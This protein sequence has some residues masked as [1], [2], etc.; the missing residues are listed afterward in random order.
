VLDYLYFVFAPE[1]PS[2]PATLPG[3]VGA[4]H[5]G[6]MQLL[7]LPSCFHL[8]RRKPFW[9]LFNHQLSIVNRQSAIGNHTPVCQNIQHGRFIPIASI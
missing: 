5:S 8:F 9:L 6:A 2:P 7:F 4:H 1:M 3:V